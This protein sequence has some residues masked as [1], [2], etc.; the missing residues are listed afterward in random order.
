MFPFNL[1]GPEFLLVF[2][3]FGVAALVALYIARTRA[4][5]GKAAGV[6]LSDPYL[7]A[8]LTGGSAHLL[9]VATLSLIDRGLL[10]ISVNGTTVRAVKP[11]AENSVRNEV[12][13]QLLRHFNGGREAKSVFENSDL[14]KRA[15]PYKQELRQLELLPSDAVQQTRTLRWLL[16]MGLLE[17]FGAIKLVV[18]LSEGRRNVEFL[19][20]L[21]IVFAIAGVLIT[22]P[23]RTR[24]GDEVV[25]DLRSLFSGLKDRCSEFR[26]GHSTNEMALLAGVFG[27]G[28]LPAS[29]YPYTKTLYPKAVD[30]G[31]SGCG[32]SSS[33]GSSC[34]GGGCGGGGCGSGCGGCGS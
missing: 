14:E 31:A 32:S 1:R 21:M 34:S 18:A 26:A 12:E 33:C 23:A 15:A 24:R 8:T 3:I 13:K 29:I 6:R 2:L 28:L 30:A 25:E 19:I 5:G 17:G 4:E 27:L 7:I 11:G 10:A 22:F 16:A 9:R 20:V